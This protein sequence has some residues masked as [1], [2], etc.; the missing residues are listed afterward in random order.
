MSDDLVAAFQLI[1]AF[2]GAGLT[3]KIA[4]LEAITQHKTKDVIRPVLAQLF[5]SSDLLRAAVA[6][7]RA[8][9]QIDTLIHAVGMLLSLCE[10]LEDGEVIESLSL[11]AGNTGKNFDLVTNTRIA[12]FTFIDW[13]GGPESMRKQKVFKDFYLLAEAETDKGRYLYFL[14]QEHAPKVFQSESACVDMLRKDVSRRR[15][16]EAKYGPAIKVR[17]YYRAN[18]GRVVL[19]DLCTVAPNAAA[20]FGLLGSP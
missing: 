13:K 19:Q 3:A 10:L 9:A 18:Q 7:K 14:G 17:E 4:E 1:S 5:V 6:V 20:V 11:G 16:L 12:E 15:A 8:A 2:R